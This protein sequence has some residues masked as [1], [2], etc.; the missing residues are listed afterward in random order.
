M[1]QDYRLIPSGCGQLFTHMADESP[2]PSRPSAG[3]LDPSHIGGFVRL[4]GEASSAEVA[5]RFGWTE[6]EAQ[7][8][9][10]QLKIKG[11]LKNRIMATK[12][13]IVAVW[14]LK[15]RAVWR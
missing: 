5:S 13:G 3:T 10:V 11:L 12:R 6:A 9:C 4:V 7:A 15:N 8:L 2:F 1:Q 14:S